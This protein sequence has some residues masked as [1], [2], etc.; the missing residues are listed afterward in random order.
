[1]E[2]RLPMELHNPVPITGEMSA[3][4]ILQPMLAR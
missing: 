2:S 3:K 1:M 4:L